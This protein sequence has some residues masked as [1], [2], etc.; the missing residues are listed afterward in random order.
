MIAAPH[1][2]L[3]KKYVLVHWSNLHGEYMG[4]KNTSKTPK[5]EFCAH[6]YNNL[7]PIRR[8]YRNED[9]KRLDLFERFGPII[10]NI[11]EKFSDKIYDFLVKKI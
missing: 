10:K 9:L 3:S 7:N 2:I 4:V 11:I 6:F 8:I 1:A 5:D